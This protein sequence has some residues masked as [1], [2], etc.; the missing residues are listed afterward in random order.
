M[1]DYKFPQL[2]GR[3]LLLH[4]VFE[5]PA[6]PA[7]LQDQYEPDAPTLLATTFRDLWS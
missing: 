5:R 1:G 7:G 3:I 2:A 4:L 6:F